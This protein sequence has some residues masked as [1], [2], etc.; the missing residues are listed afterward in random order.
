M[1]V[2]RSAAG[3]TSHDRSALRRAQPAGFGALLSAS[4]Q[5]VQVATHAAM[6][7]AT[8]AAL[9][10]PRTQTNPDWNRSPMSKAIE[11][12]VLLSLVI[13]AA[14]MLIAYPTI[15]SAQSSASDAGAASMSASTPKAVKKK[16]RKAAHNA[17]Q[18]ELKK[19]EDNGYEPSEDRANYPSDIQNAEKKA[20]GIPAA[21]TP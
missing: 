1:S 16:Q 18:A 7:H 21:S 8:R 14:L 15:A 2:V 5:V 17:R 11:R 4:V 12:G 20:N 13:V 10:L 19:L 3:S 6:S 9:R